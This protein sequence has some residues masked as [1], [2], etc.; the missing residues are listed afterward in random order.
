MAVWLKKTLRRGNTGKLIRG[1]G[2]GKITKGLKYFILNG[3]FCANQLFMHKHPY[4]NKYEFNEYSKKI[5]S[6]NFYA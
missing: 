1:R 2:L 5:H 4:M 6:L 3:A